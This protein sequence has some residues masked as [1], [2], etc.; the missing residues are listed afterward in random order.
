MADFVQESNVKSARRELSVPIADVAT[1]AGI[2]QGVLTG[3]P[4]GCTAYETTNGPQPAMEKTRENYTARI[5][6]QDDDA[7]TTGTITARAPSVAG[8]NTVLSEILGDAEMTAAM[9]GDPANDPEA[10]RYSA[11]IRCHDPSGEI[12]NVSFARGEVRVTSYEADAILAVIEAW[13]DTVPAL[14]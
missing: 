14:A 9:G 11:T 4:F 8:F 6:Y 12:Y 5:V 3:N 10:E 2:V 1:F 13:A 7:N